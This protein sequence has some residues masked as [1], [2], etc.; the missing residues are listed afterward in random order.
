[1]IIKQCF[2][3]DDEK[4][5]CK[6]TIKHL[7]VKMETLKIRFFNYLLCKKIKENEKKFLVEKV[8]FSKTHSNS[9][10]YAKYCSFSFIRQSL[11]EWMVSIQVNN[12]NNIK[13]R[14]FKIV[15]SSSIKF[16]KLSY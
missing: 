4:C 6:D 10:D 12:N 11:I 8:K 1:M 3:H 15:N 13:N 5:Y 2:A 16:L 9:K 7:Q 14:I